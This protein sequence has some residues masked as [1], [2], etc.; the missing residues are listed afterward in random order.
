[1]V[2]VA[3]GVISSGVVVDDVE[4]DS[5]KDGVITDRSRMSSTFTERLSIRLTG[6]AHVTTADRVERD[7]VDRVDLKVDVANG[8]DASNS[9][10]RPLP[11]AKGDGDVTCDDPGAQLW[12]ELHCIGDN[13]ASSTSY[14]HKAASCRSAKSPFKPTRQ[15]SA[16]PAQHDRRRSAAR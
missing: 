8:I 13:K 2:R 15:P 16:A 10:L 3:D 11:K 6:S 9:N 5:I 12:T 1:M 14:S 7:Q 4:L